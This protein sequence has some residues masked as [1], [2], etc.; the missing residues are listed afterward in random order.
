MNATL[1][2][3]LLAAVVFAALIVTADTAAAHHGYALFDTSTQKT[4]A[5]TVRIWIILP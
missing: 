1:R 3:A 4:V 2:Q 5:G